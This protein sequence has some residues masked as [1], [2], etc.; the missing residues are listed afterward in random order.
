MD[1]NRYTWQNILD[2]IPDMIALLDEQHRIVWLNNA[3]LSIMGASREDCIGKHCYKLVH[4]TDEPPDYCPH[5]KFLQ[6]K[7]A[8]S[9]EVYLDKLQGEY[10]VTISP[11]ESGN[12]TLGSIHIARDIS[13][14]KTQQREL[15]LSE[16]KFFAAFLYNPIGMCISQI[17]GKILDVNAAWSR[18]TGYSR[19]EAIGCNIQGLNLY[20]DPTQRDKLVEMVTE[21]GYANS[22]GLSFYT[23][24][25]A[26]IYGEMS[27]TAIDID[28]NA[29]W[30]TAYVDKTDTVR[31]E[32]AIKQFQDKVLL[33]AR[34]D[35]IQSLRDGIYVK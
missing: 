28:G 31:L 18:V 30:V 32:Q 2:A 5:S 35:I 9:V 27:V 22:F 8:H 24:Q 20:V 4:G 1:M 23:K 26:I 7:K 29:C 13:T 34:H 15:E 17:D 21:H 33:S 6:D 19:D 16:A 25:G 10:L 3:M 11:I 14:A 12:N